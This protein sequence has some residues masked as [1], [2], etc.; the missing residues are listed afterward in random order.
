MLIYYIE[1]EMSFNKQVIK[2]VQV[3]KQLFKCLE[4][5]KNFDDWRYYRNR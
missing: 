3:G 5:I 4:L 1:K 2:T